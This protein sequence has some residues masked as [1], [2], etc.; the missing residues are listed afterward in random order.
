MG[1]N[2]LYDLL[3]PRPSFPFDGFF[4]CRKA[5]EMKH[6]IMLLAMFG[7][8]ITTARAD[9]ENVVTSKKYV[10][11]EMA[12]LQP[13]FANLGNDKLMLYSDTTDGVVT[14]RDIVTTLGTST[15][16]D[17]I[18][19]RGAINT[20]LNT[21]QNIVN[22][23]AG[24][25]M[26]NTGLAPGSVKQKPIY[27]TT[28]NYT[29][30]LV[31]AETLNTIVTN[32]VNSELTK[33]PGIGWQI[34]TSVTLPTLRTKTNITLDASTDGT[35]Y[36]F[37]SLNSTNNKDGCS[38]ATMA[39]LGTKGN[40]SGLLGAVMPY[41]DIVGKS[42]CSAT[43]GT[44]YTAATDAQESTLTTEFNNQTGVGT[45]ALSDSQRYC[46]CKMESVNGEPAVSRWVFYYSYSSASDCA[47]YCAYHCG[48]SVQFGAD[49]R[50][51]VFGAVQ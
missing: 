13:Q 19:T 24:W 20:A 18:P 3:T 7:M 35:T 48:N 37:R 25:V 51:G 15:T 6:L 44:Q 12:K 34:N 39:T 14:S 22:G 32:A 42:V 17:S 8:F 28:N 29:T 40:K 10:D 30:A 2:T 46:W 26:E 50:S 27:S 43:A 23:N 11:D 31:E 33:L 38:T 16:A 5:R 49:F 21:K 4:N 47:D 45:S 9:D 36:C 1:V 41:G